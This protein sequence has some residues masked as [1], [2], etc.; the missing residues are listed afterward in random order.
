METDKS[1]EKSVPVDS[2]CGG[3]AQRWLMTEGLKENFLESPKAKFEEELRPWPGV[4]NK[5]PLG[6]SQRLNLSG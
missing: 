1:Q 4:L 2:K 6:M 3:M 5:Q